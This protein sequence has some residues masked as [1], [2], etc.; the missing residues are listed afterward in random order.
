MKYG[1]K[2]APTFAPVSLAEA[3]ANLRIGHNAQDDL[4]QAIVSSEINAVQTKIGRQLAQATLILYLDAYPEDD[5]V[6]IERGPVSS[7]VSVKYLQQGASELTEVP[8]ADYQLDNV[9]LTA[10]L[11]FLES[12]T[13]DIDKMN[14]IQIE[15]ITGWESGAIPDDIKHAIL[16]RVN[17]RYTNP[18]DPIELSGTST[19]VSTS[20]TL[21][22]PYAPAHC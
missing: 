9:E 7:I 12:F 5:E 22:E 18:D 2:T 17:R 15:M 8:A 14:V 21:L 13:P 3:K 16:L 11:R 6:I 19:R 20:D 10:R 1:V 4:I